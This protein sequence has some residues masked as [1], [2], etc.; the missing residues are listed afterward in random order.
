MDLDRSQPQLL[1]RIERARRVVSLC[2]QATIRAYEEEALLSETCRTLL[3]VGNYAMAWFGETIA[4]SNT[5]QPLAY[6]GAPEASGVRS[7]E[8]AWMHDLGHRSPTLRATLEQRPQVVR[9]IGDPTSETPDP[10]PT[11]KG[12]KAMCAFPIQFGPHGAGAL[13][14]YD[15]E[16]DAFAPEEVALLRELAGDIAMGV[17]G[18]RAR[19]AN[20]RL[21]AL[22]EASERRF[23][24]LIEH[25]PVAIVQFDSAG[26][27][28]TA[29]QALADLFGYKTPDEITV[30]SPEELAR[31]IDED[32][33]TAIIS[34][35]RSGPPYR[36][37]D[38][39]VHR[40]DETR[41][42]INIQLRNGNG[43]AQP[44]I[45]AFIRDLTPTR[46][47]HLAA[48]RLAA[49][50][51]SSEDAIIGVDT[52]GAVVTWSQGA[53]A[54][55]GFDDEVIGR[56]L[57]EI[58]VPE[59]RHQEWDAML[60]SLAGGERVARFDTKR[61]SKSKELKDVSVAASPIVDPDGQIVGASLT[62]HDASD[63]KRAEALRLARTRQEDEVAKWQELDRLRGDFMNRASH[64]LNTPLTPVLLQV[65]ALRDSTG[66]TE[67]QQSDLAVVE[68]NVLRLADLV[69]DL[70]RA[71]KLT[72]GRI[73]L[74][75]EALDMRELVAHAVE[76]FA[77]QASAR[78]VELHAN[79]TGPMPA[80][81]DADRA[82]QVLFNLLGNALKYTPSGGSI[83]VVSTEREGMFTLTITDS[84]LGFPE[85][86]RPLLFSPFG[87]LHDDVAGAPP[88]NGL[89]LFISKG[90]V[91]GSGG[92][93]WAQ[94]AGV[95]EGAT[96]G[97][98][99]PQRPIQP[100]GKGITAARWLDPKTGSDAVEDPQGD[101][102]AAPGAL[103]ATTRK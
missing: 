29:N 66:L 26:K 46:A 75:A 98:T 16:P 8:P 59:D 21:E 92:E 82:T 38:L 61:L 28:L 99:L 80:Y 95:G 64:E 51:D 53:E 47:A 68:R 57:A 78:N 72:S 90:I 73:E 71:S 84:G 34:D 83:D 14:V 97:F 77:A 10:G 102:T 39:E 44:A 91:E 5:L 35:I 63:R 100:P 79:A 49:V 96:F 19:Q 22:V 36:P 41:L 101:P 13:T 86:K 2:S 43:D 3:D 1:Q 6:A 9:N 25:A 40:A 4:G 65:Q 7:V 60:A 42:W 69:K 85:E 17:A 58:Y 56:Q 81:A 76:T 70:L 48:S 18:L 88:G 93:M 33:L 67:K 37:L 103:P 62:E 27:V 31:H 54:L 89:G 32:D 12:A 11:P 87:C 74:N 15:H 30:Q 24:G 55:Y 20:D 50:V 52:D 94:S 45:E 23:R